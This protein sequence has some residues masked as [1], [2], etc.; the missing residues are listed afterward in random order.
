MSRQNYISPATIVLLSNSYQVT[1]LV[2]E[3]LFPATYSLLLPSSLNELECIPKKS[4]RIPIAMRQNYFSLKSEYGNHLNVFHLTQTAG[5]II[6]QIYKE[7]TATESFDD[8]NA[9]IRHDFGG[10]PVYTIDDESAHELDDGISVEE[11]DRGIWLHIH[12][13]NP[14]AFLSPQSHIA[15]LARLRQTSMYLPDRMH[16][17]LPVGDENFSARGFS[18]DSKVTPTMTFSARLS[19]DGNIADYKSSTRSSAKCQNID[20]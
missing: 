9:D 1:S 11:T 13:A 10:L 18:K 12:I 14:S 5:V 7:Q 4:H 19:S 6:D 16:P 2:V 8:A 3:D 17:M 15:Q 20:L